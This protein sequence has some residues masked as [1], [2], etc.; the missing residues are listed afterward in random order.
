MIFVRFCF[1]RDLGPGRYLL[2]TSSDGRS[3]VLS[4]CVGASCG[5][6][7]LA[8]QGRAVVLLSPHGE[9][10]FPSLEE[11]IRFY[12]VHD[13]ADIGGVALSDCIPLAAELAE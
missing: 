3:F 10:K 4:L 1:C 7:I 12:K 2:R 8:K 5:H 9:R 11:C 13:C 6:F